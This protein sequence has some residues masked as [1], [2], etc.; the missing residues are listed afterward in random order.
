MEFSILLNKMFVFVVLMVIGYVLARRGVLDKSFTRAA[1]SLTL[2]VFMAATIVNSVLSMDQRLSWGEVGRV[3][4]VMW[5]MQLLGYAGAALLIRVLPCDPAHKPGYELLMSMGNSMFIALPIVEAL[6]GSIAVF[7]MSISC[8]PFNVLLYTYGV[9]RLRSDPNDKGLRLKDI[10]CVP[11][12]ATLVSLALFFLH[13]PIP[14]A[15]R[16]L[17]GSMAGA[18][19]PMSMIVIGSSLGSVKLLDAFRSGK[20]YIS[21]FVRLALIPGLTFLVCRLLTGDPVLLMTAVITA[22]CPSAVVVTVLSIQ[23]GRDAVFTAEGTLQST[24]LSM[25]TI[26]LWVWL[27]G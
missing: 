24:V 13:P 7:Y 8:I 2:N 6:Y 11:L 25:L 10:L 21:S 17:I 4:L 9:W 1:S 22:A 27:L 16:G 14:A 20:L 3:L 15:V 18:T 23:Y 26:P 19:M 12:I 5:V